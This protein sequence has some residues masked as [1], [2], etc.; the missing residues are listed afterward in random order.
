MVGFVGGFPFV[1]PK[2]GQRPL[3]LVPVYSGFELEV[4]P[5]FEA[6]SSA[7]PLGVRLGANPPSCF[8]AEHVLEAGRIAAGMLHLQPPF[9]V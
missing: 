9:P 2:V 5:P 8:A 3:A 6:D 1:L 4:L 7:P